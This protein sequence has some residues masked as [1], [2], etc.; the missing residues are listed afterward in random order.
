MNR[1]ISIIHQESFEQVLRVD[2]GL[3]KKGFKSAKYMNEY[4]NTV[5]TYNDL[6]NLTEKYGK[7]LSFLGLTQLEFILKD[8]MWNTTLYTI[9]AVSK[10]KRIL[11]KS[12][13]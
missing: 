6:H 5:I 7:Y 11:K 9:L 2:A 3:L 1:T 10:F 13:K 8:V 12:N 4:I